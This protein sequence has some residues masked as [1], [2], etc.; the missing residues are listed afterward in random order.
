MYGMSKEIMKE[1]KCF[2]CDK[3]PNKKGD[4]NTGKRYARYNDQT[5]QQL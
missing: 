1:D 5:D 4:L 2:A 3:K